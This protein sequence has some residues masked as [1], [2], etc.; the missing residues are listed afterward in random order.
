MGIA[1]SQGW[2]RAKILMP[3]AI[4]ASSG[5]MCTLVG[6][7]P[8]IT[9]NTTLVNAG[10]EIGFFDYALFGLPVAIISIVY[11]MLIGNRLIPVR[12]SDVEV[13]DEESGKVYDTKKQIIA[14]AVLVGVI[15]CMVTKILDLHDA[16]VVGAILCVVTGCMTEKEAYQSFDWQTIFLFAGA[17]GLAT[18]MKSTGAGKI[19]ADQVVDM[20]GGSPNPIV[21]TAVLFVITGL[22]TQF[23]SNTAAAALLCPIGLSIAESLGASPTAVVLAIGFSASAA[24]MTPVATP[25]NT[26]I[27]GPGGLQFMDY[28]KVG[29][30]LF[31]IVMIMA[32]VLMPIIWPFF[33]NA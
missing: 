28:V 9:A 1:D 22:L 27:Y 32:L 30:P 17:L 2:N 12:H 25:P 6:T 8:N 5:G 19:L 20:M 13:A 23:M 10:Y 26:M 21:L 31:I 18:A 15:V 4:M 14:G 29:T 24:Y 3:L 7:P 16:A 33:P 11:M